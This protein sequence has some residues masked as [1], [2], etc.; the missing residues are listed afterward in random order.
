MWAQIITFEQDI[1][2]KVKDGKALENF[3][4]IFYKRGTLHKGSIMIAI[5]I[6]VDENKYSP[7]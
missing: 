6:R 7:E 5:F 1:W 2:K 4:W 3:K